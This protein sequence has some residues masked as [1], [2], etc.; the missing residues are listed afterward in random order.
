MREILEDAVRHFTE[1]SVDLVECWLPRQHPYM[2]SLSEVGFVCSRDRVGLEFRTVWACPS[3]PLDTRMEIRG[4]IGV[5]VLARS[6]GGFPAN[7]QYGGY[8]AYE[9]AGSRAGAV[10]RIQLR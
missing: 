10:R 9:S 4:D 3:Y 1:Q 6:R 8:L 5:I 2:R 7:E